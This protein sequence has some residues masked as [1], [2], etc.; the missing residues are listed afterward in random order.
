MTKE[1][2]QQIIVK[3]ECGTEQGTGFFITPNR[4]LTAYHVVEQLEDGEKNINSI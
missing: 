2:V 4:I 3:I 1:Q